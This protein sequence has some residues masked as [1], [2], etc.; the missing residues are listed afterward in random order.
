MTTETKR[1]LITGASRGIG[2]ATA[3]R[4]A[5]EGMLLLLHGR[6]Q[7]ALVEVF[8][9]VEDRGGKAEIIVADLY[10]DDGIEKLI[11][12]ASKERLDILINNAGAAIV[13]PLADLTLDDWQDMLDMN[14]TLPFRLVQALL[15][16]IPKGGSIVNIMSVAA[17]HGFPGWHGYCASK[18]ALEGLSQV[19]RAELRSEGIRVINIYPAATATELWENVE[20]DWPVDE[21]MDPAEVAEAVAY[22]LSRPAGILADNIDVGNL[23]GNF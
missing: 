12:E 22:A 18:F 10:E 9:A 11:Q 13:K 23:S 1:C 5:Q 21:M 4:L 16:A 7:E 3:E 20:G 8:T 6:D 17:R 2:R 14:V 19:L 15:P